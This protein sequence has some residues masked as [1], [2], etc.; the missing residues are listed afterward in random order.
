MA[1]ATSAIYMPFPVLLFV[2]NWDKDVA[3]TS[4]VMVVIGG[5][6]PAILKATCVSFSQALSKTVLSTSLFDYLVA[7]QNFVFNFGNACQ[8]EIKYPVKSRL[9]EF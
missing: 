2:H 1:V 8:G 5:I 9:G 3:V 4:P 7:R 6:F